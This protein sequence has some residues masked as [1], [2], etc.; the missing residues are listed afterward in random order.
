MAKQ[1]RPDPL[2]EALKQGIPYTITM[3]GGGDLASMRKAVKHG[4]TLTF[5]PV[6]DPAAVQVGNIVL[7]KWRG[8]NTMMHLVGEISDDRFLIVNSLG[9][10]N[11]W[12]TVD[13]ILGYVTQTI[14]PDPRP[15][16]PQM[17]DE[18]EAA[19][20][21]V[22][23]RTNPAAEDRARLLTV[24]DDL[25]WY[26]VAI[27]PEQWTKL[28]RLNLWSF[29]ERLWQLLRKAQ[30]AAQ[31]GAADAVRTLLNHGKE[32]VGQVATIFKVLNAANEAIEVTNGN[33]RTRVTI[34]N[35]N[36]DDDLVPL[37]NLRNL[38][39]GT[40]AAPITIAQ[41][42][43]KFHE[44]NQHPTTDH[45]VVEETGDSWTLLGQS[46]GYHTVPERYLAW[47]EVHPDWRR[48][49]LGSKLLAKVIER[50]KTVG[51]DHILINADSN[52]KQS[53]AHAF[54]QHHG[55]LAKADNWFLHAPAD[56]EVAPPTLPAGYSI[57]T[58]AEVQ[59]LAILW[60]VCY[61]SYGDQWGHGENSRINREKPA[62][63]TVIDWVTAAAPKGENIFLLFD[64]AD[65][66]AG[67]CRGFVGKQAAAAMPTGVID[68]PGVVL[69]YRHLDLQRPLL[70]AVMQ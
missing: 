60:Q 61:Q 8:G 41:Q 29:E 28:P 7:V 66:V 45:W 59:D 47:L 23:E 55:F 33:K 39:A 63:T 35:V 6:T 4:Q 56:L 2:I 12:V 62:E 15:T 70:L 14:D 10:E 9:T 1:K 67:V 40:G 44:P 18:L 5:S 69:K 43:E 21:A 24:A 16:V 57:R 52:E 42:Q 51:A 48:H 50:A 32:Q 36:M 64:E 3:F 11:G 20:R 38:C 17:L 31:H 46:F 65:N 19:Y 30:Q 37:V 13:A 34:R 53:A 22:I 54:L 26:T 68:A 58:F 25:R 49:G 27:E